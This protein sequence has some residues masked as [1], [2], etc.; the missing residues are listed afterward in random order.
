MRI[1]LWGDGTRLL[2]HLIPSG[3]LGGDRVGRARWGR[4][5]AWTLDP[6]EQA[7]RADEIDEVRLRRFVPKESWW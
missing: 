4:G 3:L 5:L 1:A 2:A 6:D 7:D